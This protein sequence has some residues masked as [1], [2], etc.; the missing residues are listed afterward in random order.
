MGMLL[1]QHPPDAHYRLRSSLDS[2]TLFHKSRK[3]LIVLR[4][5]LPQETIATIAGSVTIPSSTSG[6]RSISA[7]LEINKTFLIILL[8]SYFI[9]LN[10]SL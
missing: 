1:S 3:T 2:K 4:K 7:M 10:T 9:F 5:K 8:S 6:Y